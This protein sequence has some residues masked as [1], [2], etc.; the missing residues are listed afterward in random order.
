MGYDCRKTTPFTEMLAECRACPRGLTAG[1]AYGE[2]LLENPAR[3]ATLFLLS[4]AQFSSYS[5][6]GES[7]HEASFAPHFNVDHGKSIRA[8]VD[9]AARCAYADR[10]TVM[11]G[12]TGETFDLSYVDRELDVMRTSKT[13]LF[14]V[15][16]QSKK[17]LM[18]DL[19]FARTNE[20]GAMLVEGKIRRDTHPVLALVQVL[21][22]AAHLVTPAQRRRL[23][24]VYSNVRLP[25]AAPYLDVAVL[26]VDKPQRGKA[27]ALLET[28]KA[29]AAELLKTAGVGTL[30]RH[31][32]FL[33]W[34]DSDP[35]SLV[36]RCV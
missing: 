19:L 3:L 32:Y 23:E 12:E 27:V 8:A 31:I 2:R 13:Q 9:L 24:N 1:E 14:D 21:A 18:L 20:T 30:I 15:G 10:V 16:G 7:F 5:N 35:R 4:V 6:V 26:L 36:L 34:D 29:L 33:A 22:A 25:S 17:A 11:C 28:A